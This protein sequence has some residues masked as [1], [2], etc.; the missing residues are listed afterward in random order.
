MA[1][2]V[3]VT[4]LDALRRLRTAVPDAVRQQLGAG[5]RRRGAAGGGGC[6]IVRAGRDGHAAARD[7]QQRQSA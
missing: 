4:G 7:H 3:T 5:A 2:K 6:A 1:F